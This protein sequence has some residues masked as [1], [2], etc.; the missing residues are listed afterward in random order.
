MRK[1]RWTMALFSPLLL[2]WFGCVDD[3][4]ATAREDPLE[5]ELAP[6]AD[7]SDSVR[8]EEIEL[9]GLTFHVRTAGPARGEL[10]ILLHGFPE[11]SYEWRKTMPALA[12]AGYRVV[13]PDLRGYS[14]GARPL[15]VTQ[16]N[17][18]MFVSDVL[19][20][21]DHLR[22]PRFHLVGHDV[23]GLVAW[24]T[25]QF[26]G[27]RVKSLTALSVP[28]PG[29]F[30]EQLAD[31]DSCQS[32]ASAWYADVMPLDA[33]QKQLDDEDSLLRQ[34]WS[35]REPDAAEEYERLLGTPA[36]LDGALNV[37]RANFVNGQPQGALPIPVLVPTL[38]LL[39]DRDP[40]NCPE[41]EPSTKRLTWAPY[42]FELLEGVGHWIPEDA[43]DAFNR[44]LL[45]HLRRN[46]F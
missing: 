31:P 38:Y 43:A 7:S 42:R 23:G 25:A 41:A 39:G 36:A 13:A 14:P 33:A 27:L 6:L 28:H 40:Y 45:S 3:P 19:A 18:L 17:L 20:L 10:V 15:E 21:A 46:R 9:N 37:W 1:T 12:R 16:Y 34:V 35:E 24:G 30:A 44:L 32:E 2:A 5:P 4:R 11:S 29:A 26:F 8:S 22:A